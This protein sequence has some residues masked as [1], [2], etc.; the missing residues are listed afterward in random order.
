MIAKF[1]GYALLVSLIV[2]TLSYGSSD[3]VNVGARDLVIELLVHG[4]YAHYDTYVYYGNERLLKDTS[5]NFWSSTRM[6]SGDEGAAQPSHRFYGAGLDVLQC[7]EVVSAARQLKVDT[8]N[9]SSKGIGCNQQRGVVAYIVRI[10]GTFPDYEEEVR[11]SRIRGTMQTSIM[12]MFV[13]YNDSSSSWQFVDSLTVDP[14][15]ERPGLYTFGGLLIDSAGVNC[16]YKKRNYVLRYSLQDGSID[17]LTGCDRVGVPSNSMHLLTLST[18]RGQL[19]LLD[20]RGRAISSI[21]SNLKWISDVAAVS[22]DAF[23]VAGGRPGLFG[24]GSKYVVQLVDFSANKTEELCEVDGG[25]E[26]LSLEVLR[27]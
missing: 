3:T 18:D 19:N 15:A 7:P 12:D 5:I 1:A 23:V 14:F 20:E 21:R 9:I 10:L 13:I 4:R 8:A 6:F 22:D 2:A 24:I 17:T 27:E 26:I 11:G 25:I 16:Y